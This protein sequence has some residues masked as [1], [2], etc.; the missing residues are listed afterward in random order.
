MDYRKLYIGTVIR[1]SDTVVAKNGKAS[2]PQGKVLVKIEGISQTN[3]HN[4]DYKFPLGK[5]KPG[6]VSDENIILLEGHEIEAY[7]LSHVVGGD[8]PGRYFDK[9]PKGKTG[10]TATFSETHDVS[11]VSN[12][13]NGT[14]GSSIAGQFAKGK[15]DGHT[16]KPDV[17]GTAGVNP[18]GKFYQ[19]NYKDGQSTGSFA[20]P[21]VGARVLIGFINGSRALPVV[22][23]AIHGGP[24]VAGINS[25][26]G[27]PGAYPNY[28]NH[29]NV[30]RPQSKL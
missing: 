8:S 18:Y 11:L 14:Q 19:V 7:V 13:N 28:P 23:G 15:P 1:C 2:S 22:L 21:G 30:R 29:A 16:G 5:N 12:T 20:I 26:A 10:G 24:A 3:K 27:A 6:T 9:P 4:E 17:V 25:T